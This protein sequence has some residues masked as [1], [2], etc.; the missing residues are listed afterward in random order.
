MKRI[1]LFLL[2]V[3]FISCSSSPNGCIMSEDFISE[4]LQ[5]PATAEFSSFDCSCDE[6]PDGTYTV[7]RKVAAENAFGVK[8]E[9]IYKLV[10]SYNG[11]EWTDKSNWTLISMDSEEYR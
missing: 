3:I 2:F 8:K 10:L 9:F 6:N 11:E 1:V 5:N 7:L 4:D